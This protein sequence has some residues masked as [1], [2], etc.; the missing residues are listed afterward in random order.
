MSEFPDVE[1]VSEILRE[2]AAEEILPRFQRLSASEVREKGPGDLVTVADE[3]SERQ[4]SRRLADLLPGSV[5]VGEEEAAGDDGVLAR[6]GGDEWVWIIDPVDGTANFAAGRPT[7]GVMVALARD[8]ETRAGWIYDPCGG[9]MGIAVKGDGAWLDGERLHCAA[10]APLAAMTGALSMRF[11]E[12]PLRQHLEER[13][14]G[15]ARAF[16]LGCAAHEYLSLASGDIHFAVYRKIMP[17]D[18]AAGALMH[19]EAG[20]YHTKLDG[21]RYGPTEWSGGLM[22]APDRTSWIALRDY[23]F[24]TDRRAAARA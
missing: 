5:V 16:T 21:G 9:R 3:A 12:K 13:A 19:E 4:L 8:G 23:L 6:I 2:V 7:F 22:L 1:R 18:H 20:G 15:L 10:P 24:D 11:F 14:R 17:W